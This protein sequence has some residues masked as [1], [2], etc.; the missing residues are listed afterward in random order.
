MGVEVRWLGGTSRHAGTPTVGCDHQELWP[1]ERTQWEY[2]R[3]AENC[4]QLEPRRA[5]LLKLG[6]QQWVRCGEQVSESLEPPSRIET[7]ER[8]LGQGWLT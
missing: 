2:S 3:R 7:A 6:H 1:S 8:H 4:C 5:R